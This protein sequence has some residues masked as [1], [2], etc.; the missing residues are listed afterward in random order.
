MN[1]VTGGVD[2][3]DLTAGGGQ[4]PAGIGSPLDQPLPCQGSGLNDEA[5]WMLAVS[6]DGL[7]VAFASDDGS[8]VPADT[9]N[10]CDVFAR[11]DGL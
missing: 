7:L 2:R 5:R 8:I 3:V 10:L 6:R 4:I 11:G 9:N 1:R